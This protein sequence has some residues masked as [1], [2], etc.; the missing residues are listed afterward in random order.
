[1]YAV[2]W[3]EI[4][5]FLS[6]LIG[7]VVITVFLLMTG[8]FIWVFKDTNILEYNYAGLE[9]LFSIAPLVFTFLIPAI[10]MRSFSEERQQGTIELLA[11]KP[12]T[13]TQI[14]M[15]KYM[16]NLTLVV[17]AILPTLIYYYSVY[18][19]G[20]PKGNIDNGAVVG[21][22]IG[23]TFLAGIFVSIGLFC[24]SISRN[25][26]IAFIVGAFLCF[27]MHWAFNYLSNLSIFFGK[28]D[29]L[30]QKLGINYHYL[31]ISKGKIDSRDVIYFLSVIFLFIWFTHVALAKRKWA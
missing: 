8:L 19:L 1:M 16:A 31:S 28:T 25:Q 9:Q 13:D 17:F 5:S 18:Q 7:Y 2:F 26:I 22:Y 11:T 24:S 30:V 4:R 14:I 15:G 21:S 12:L 20:S 29:D 10:T 23:L 3:K 6:S 27:F